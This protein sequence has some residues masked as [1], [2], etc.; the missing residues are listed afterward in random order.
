MGTTIS[1]LYTSGVTLSSAAYD[2]TTVTSTAYLQQGLKVTYAGPW[3]VVNQ[4]GRIAGDTNYGIYLFD[5]GT[6]TNQ[7]GGYISGG[8]GGIVGENGALTVVNSGA[9]YGGVVGITL[10][11]GGDVTNQAGGTISGY[12]GIYGGPTAAATVV[13]DGVIS[14]TVSYTAASFASAGVALL[15]GG[16]ITNQSGGLIVG[17]QGVYGGHE[18]ALTVVNAGTIA[19][20]YFSSVGAAFGNGVY[21]GDGGTLVNQAGGTIIG[22]TG[23]ATS[24]VPATVVNDGDVTGIMSTG[25]D[26]G[27]GGSL[28]NQS[29]GV[30]VGYFGVDS[31]AYLSVVNAGTIIGIDFGGVSLL[32]GGG[33]VTNQARGIITG[34]D[35]VV[36]RDSTTVI[37]AGSI[38]GTGA[39]GVGVY[40]EGGGSVTNQSGG[41]ISGYSGIV[42]VGTIPAYGLGPLTVV[43]AGDIAGTGG[44]GV[45]LDDGGSVTN[46]AGGT[47]SGPIGIYSGSAGVTVVNDGTILGTGTAA[48]FDAAVALL[49]GGYVTNQ[50]D[51]T[52][53]GY[54]GIYGGYNGGALTVVNA[55]TIAGPFAGVF[56]GS[57]GAVTNQ[58]SGVIT[59]YNAGISAGTFAMTLVNY[60]HIAAYGGAGIAMGGGG[61]VYNQAGGTIDGYFGIL[62]GQAAATVV[63]AGTIIGDFG[64]VNF[65]SGGYL[66]NQSGGTVTGNSAV[67]AVS[68]ATVVN[69]GSIVATGD[70]GAGVQLHAGGNL[71]NQ[72]GGVITGYYNGVYGGHGALTT[73]VNAGT[74]SGYNGYGVY[75]L[76]RGSITN[77]SGGTISGYHGI[78]AISAATVVNAG[79]IYGYLGGIGLQAGGTVN[80][81]SGGTIIGPVGIYGGGRTTVVN[82]GS[83][84]GGSNGRY[85]GGIALI[86]GGIVTNE[87]TGTITGYDGVYGGDNGRLTVVNAGGIT[88]DYNGVALYDGGR[89]TNQSGGTIIGGY[90]GIY[91][92]KQVT[93]VNAGTIIGGTTGHYMGGVAL[94]GGGSITNQAGGTIS[95]YSG[96]YGHLASMTVVNAGTI[97]GTNTAVQFAA[98]YTNLLTI[99]PGAVFGG[100]VDGGNTIGA[101]AVSTIELAPGA[102]GGTLSGLET[103]F[104][105]FAQVTVDVGASWTLTGDNTL[106]AGTTL[107]NAGT[108]TILDTTLSDA[109]LVVNNGNIQID[110]SSVTLADLIGTGSVS[111]DNGSTLDVLGTVSSGETIVFAG[112]ND[113][114]GTNPT[115]FAGQINGFTFGDTI[116]LAG[117]TDGLSAEIVNGNTLEILRSGGSPVD[118]TLDPSVDYTGDVYAIDST[119]AV[120][121]VAPCFVNGTLIR[122]ERGD[123]PVELLA[124]GDR[125]VTLS[126]SL[127][128]I[129]WIGYRDLDLTR[130][131]APRC[132][133]PIVIRTH[134]F[135]G[136]IP[137]RDLFL[138]PEHA[139]LT[140]GGLVPVRLLVN[141]AS[142]QRVSERRRVTYYHVE[143]ETHDILLAEGLAVESYLET[144]NRGMFANAGEPLRLY[145]NLTNDQ[146]RRTAESCAP[147]V[148]DPERV[149]PMWQA[150]AER[151]VQLGWALP[152]ALPTTDDPALCLIVDGRQIAPVC[153]DQG[154]HVFMVPAG[155]A[156]VR[157]RSRAATPS[158]ATPWVSDDRRLGVLLRGLTVRSGTDAMP[159]PLDDPGFGPGWWQAEWHSPTILRRWT[160]GDAVV[161]I[162][163][164]MEGVCL[165][166]V[167]VAATLSYPLPLAVFNP[168]PIRRSA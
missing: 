137:N 72:A 26:M 70:R 85:T 98:G 14:G 5:G 151:A 32:V 68:S 82:A 6:V 38:Y 48:Y 45:S 8:P 128:P 89:V 141:G 13:N 75:L 55:G 159:I 152:A 30:I 88:G 144:G 99:D 149:R 136:G 64:G 4:G 18:G 67:Y 106:E 125:V 154:K 44:A 168:L 90:D 57:G 36:G 162:P 120:T 161:S 163:E 93:V 160:D 9:I 118:L 113:L 110:P 35:G 25:I 83:I 51:G 122:T 10:F 76:G 150:L 22:S 71:T 148:D 61:A 111:I 121:E 119:G 47:I 56:L 12:T 104:V 50:S 156:E 155:S 86:G 126:G 53:T 153:V 15:A 24:M 96:I 97:I 43:N 158:D 134:A 52:I 138:S 59:G 27:A 135:G 123:V 116:D 147:F 101:T 103:Q 132:V 142:I 143:L 105:D 107:T 115:A 165:L 65:L 21:L 39:G 41:T 130:H 112:T 3:Q 129:R 66:T 109:G 166:E 40:L 84:L 117:V 102:S 62:A 58:V 1:G 77:Q 164:R 94:F 69:A 23:I 46:Q 139:V 78:G 54:Q 131:P 49:A 95:G 108:L 92:Y 81:Q 16:Y 140:D 2:P 60:G 100:T 19:A 87:S 34:N 167:E 73:V 157:L 29:N 133:Q 127:R 80:N 91:A 20:T 114:L 42:G 37:N 17:Y 33:S 31:A 146:A 7:A 145:P 79:T 74:I 63:N 11:D 28:T 124:V